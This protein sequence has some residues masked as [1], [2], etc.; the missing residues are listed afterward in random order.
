MLLTTQQSDASGSHTLGLIRMKSLLRF[1]PSAV[2]N[3]SN[4]APST[5]TPLGVHS[6]PSLDLNDSSRFQIIT[7][8]DRAMLSS[9]SSTD[10]VEIDNLK[11]NEGFVIDLTY[12]LR[13]RIFRAKGFCDSI[14]QMLIFAATQSPKTE[15]SGPVSAYNRDEDYTI[16][17]R[18]T[19]DAASENLP[20]A[21]LIEIVACLPSAMY[22]TQR[23]GIWAELDGRA[24]V[25]GAY[26]AKITVQ[27]GDHSYGGGIT[28][29]I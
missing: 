10:A 12:P 14:I 13:G 15:A 3:T 20:W 24:R 19:S 23:G 4:P 18:P 29:M 11:N 16:S 7:S 22:R 1:A 26:I 8:L 27:T 21:K 5:D 9:A 28:C 25:N 6:A 17:V 2:G